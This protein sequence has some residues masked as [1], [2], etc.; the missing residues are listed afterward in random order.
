[1][2]IIIFIYR[3]LFFDII[4]SFIF[5]SMFALIEGDVSFSNIIFYIVFIL[6]TLF[7]SGYIGIKWD[8][9]NKEVRKKK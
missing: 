7:V 5:G 2:R 3:Y 9:F 6:I 8:E 4:L 1:M